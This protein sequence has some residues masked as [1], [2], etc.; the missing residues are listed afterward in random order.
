MFEAAAAVKLVSFIGSQADLITEDNP[1]FPNI[2][3]PPDIIFSDFFSYEQL[4]IVLKSP[5]LDLH[6]PGFTRDLLTDQKIWCIAAME[7]F[8]VCRRVL[9]TRMII[10]RDPCPQEFIVPENG[11]GVFLFQQGIEGTSPVHNLIR[12]AIDKFFHVLFVE[13]SLQ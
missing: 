10:D 9:C 8:D 5:G 11:D 3:F 13:W 2:A 12:F 4:R 6:Q 7:L 1:E